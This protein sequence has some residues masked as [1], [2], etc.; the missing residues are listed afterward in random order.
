M[1]FCLHLL[2]GLMMVC[3]VLQWYV[4]SQR[5]LGSINCA[6][7]SEVLDNCTKTFKIYFT[8]VIN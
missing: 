1:L 3:L 4:Y 7:L 6:R 2:L 8:G 5:F